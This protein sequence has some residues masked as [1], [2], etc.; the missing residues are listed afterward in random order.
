MYFSVPFGTKRTS[1]TLYP[2]RQPANFIIFLE[3]KCVELSSELN[4]ERVND[5][6]LIVHKKSLQ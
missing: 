5:A 3:L 6:K 2:D 1:D 4:G